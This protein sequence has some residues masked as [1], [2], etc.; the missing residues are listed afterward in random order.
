M[1]FI[2]SDFQ[3]ISLYSDEMER[4]SNQSCPS[5]GL[6]TMNLNELPGRW[7]HQNAVYNQKDFCQQ[8]QP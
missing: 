5:S 8:C 2:I 6:A 7:V 3:N 1:V 4:G